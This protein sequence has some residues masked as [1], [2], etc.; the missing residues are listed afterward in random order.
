MGQHDAETY[1]PLLSTRVCKAGAR[2]MASMT[3][4]LRMPIALK[5]TPLDVHCILRPVAAPALEL[6]RATN[7]ALRAFCARAPST[8]VLL[9]SVS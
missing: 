1:S 3:T 7:D 9:A 8:P 5:R 2:S 6:V 4:P